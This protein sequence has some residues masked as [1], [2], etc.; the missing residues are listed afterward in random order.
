MNAISG[1]KNLMDLIQLVVAKDSREPVKNIFSIN[2]S[3]QLLIRKIF[4]KS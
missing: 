3:H 4:L 2:P 1:W